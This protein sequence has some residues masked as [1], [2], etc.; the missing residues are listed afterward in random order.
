MSVS[1]GAERFWSRFEIHAC[2]WDQIMFAGRA[3]IRACFPLP[4][5]IAVVCAHRTRAISLCLTN[6]FPLVKNSSC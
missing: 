3:E 1:L 2:L 6:S 4:R 5:C